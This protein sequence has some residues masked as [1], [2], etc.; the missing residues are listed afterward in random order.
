MQTPAGLLL[1]R[2]SHVEDRPAVYAA[3]FALSHAAWLVAYPTA[4]LVGASFGL[5]SA[6]LVL[7]LGAA[8]GV[9][10]AACVWPRRES[11]E[12]V[13]EHAAIEHDHPIEEDDHHRH[14]A[15]HRLGA[16]RHRHRPLRHAHAFV[17]DDHHPSWPRR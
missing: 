4:G 7:T 3:Q 13:H 17:I 11:A 5:P 9:L 12:L 10:A 15:V 1:A 8:A 2:S 16:T 14:R 6:F